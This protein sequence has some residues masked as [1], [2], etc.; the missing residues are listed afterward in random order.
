MARTG[1]PWARQILGGGILYSIGAAAYALKWPDPFPKVFGYHGRVA[2]SLLP[3]IV[4]LDLH[5]KCQDSVSRLNP[6]CLLG[7]LLAVLTSCSGPPKRGPILQ[8]EAAS[9]L[10]QGN[11]L[12]QRRPGK[13][14]SLMFLGV[15]GV[16]LQKFSMPLSS[17]HLLC[18]SVPWRNWF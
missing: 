1:L 12:L 17:W 3:S 8:L 10:C 11:F 9:S 4:S 13:H 6:V 7:K 15:K 5:S 14:I 16:C 18:T 2:T